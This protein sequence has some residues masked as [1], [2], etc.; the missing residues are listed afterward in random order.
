MNE[1]SCQDKADLEKGHIQFGNR[2]I[3]LWGTQMLLNLL[4][5]HD[6]RTF[7]AIV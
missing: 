6:N 7:T 1:Y 2:I 3:A 4:R 5:G